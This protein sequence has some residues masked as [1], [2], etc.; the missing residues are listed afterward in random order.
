MEHDINGWAGLLSAFDWVLLLGLVGLSV[1]FAAW[2]ALRA[3]REVPN[4]AEEA[5]LMGRGLSGPLFVATLVASW[6]GD[7][8][9][10]TQLAFEEGVYQFITQ[11]LCWYGGYLIFAFFLAKK[12]RQSQALSLPDLIGKH[13]GPRCA[14]AA[15]CLI[16]AKMLPITYCLGV[17]YLLQG[18]WPSLS[19]GNGCLLGMAFV[20]GYSLFGG[21]R[22]VVWSDLIQC[23][24]FF[25]A[26]FAVVLCAYLRFGGLDFLKSHV[27]PALLNPH[28]SWGRIGVWF[29]VASMTTLVSPV[30]YQRCFA[31]KSDRIAQWG[32]V[33]SVGLWI[34]F[35][36]AVCL[37]GLYA[38]AVCPDAPSAT[39]YVHFSLGILPS[40]LRGLFI[41]GLFATLFSTLDTHLH[42]A[43]T[44][45][46]YELFP[47]IQKYLKEGLLLSLLA[48]LTL[49]ICLQLEHPHFELLWLIRKRYF[50]ACLLCPIAFCLLLP[51]TRSDTQGLLAMLASAVTI[52]FWPGAWGDPL[53]PGCL[54]GLVS[55][56][57]VSS[58]EKEKGQGERKGPRGA[59]A[60]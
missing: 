32:I 9:G 24:T 39:A 50:I 14:K 29:V 56:V 51:K 30:F 53:V 12:A 60:P 48:S 3:P 13:F 26:L 34:L 6:Y 19:L 18:L 17:G 31:A 47:K 10:V 25:A 20:V 41:A 4:T 33:G 58:E 27:P 54:A 23:L 28:H 35:D 8:V 52:T 22:A 15:T 2:G 49:L 40:G 45:L 38:R 1:V 55:L 11:G 5:I 16:I 44:T 37:G 46:R 42:L 43:S 36:S 57:A 7:I 59:C 21:L